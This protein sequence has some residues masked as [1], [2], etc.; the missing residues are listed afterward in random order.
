[1]D[2]LIYML[3]VKRHMMLSDSERHSGEFVDTESE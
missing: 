2:V 1:M 3:L